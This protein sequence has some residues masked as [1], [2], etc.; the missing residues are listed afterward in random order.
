MLVRAFFQLSFEMKHQLNI[1]DYSSDEHVN[2]SIGW[3]ELRYQRWNNRMRVWEFLVKKGF[4]GKG[5]G[6]FLMNR[7]VEVAI[8]KGARMVVLETQS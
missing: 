8:E 3:V 5:V 7:A 2:R 4:R 6:T 1:S